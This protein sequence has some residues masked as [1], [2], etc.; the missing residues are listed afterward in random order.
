MFVFLNFKEIRLWPCCMISTMPFLERKWWSY[1][2][3]AAISRLGLLLFL[4]SSNRRTFPLV[5]F[6]TNI[7][8]SSLFTDLSLLHIAEFT[9]THW[10]IE[11]ASVLL[12]ILPSPQSIAPC[13]L[14][15]F[16]STRTVR[17]IWGTRALVP[18]LILLWFF[19]Y[20]V[21]KYCDNAPI[22]LCFVKKA[23]THLANNDHSY[24]WSP[25][26]RRRHVKS[27]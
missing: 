27:N 21:L 2:L 9:L 15:F 20:R 25:C 14:N 11:P 10:H 3:N 22:K 13:H 5:G 26:L 8:L 18:P 6:I 12:P 19:W 24:F 1:H 16:L 4:L 17:N 7:F 23:W